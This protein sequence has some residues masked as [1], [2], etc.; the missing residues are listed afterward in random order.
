MNWGIDKT[1]TTKRFILRK[2]ARV[3][4]IILLAFFENLKLNMC[5]IIPFW[6]KFGKALSLLYQTYET[7]KMKIS[8]KSNVLFFFLGGGGGGGRGGEVAKVSVLEASSLDT[9]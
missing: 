6:A 8:P 7:A 5:Q 1:C 3:I 4:M 2:V 9:D